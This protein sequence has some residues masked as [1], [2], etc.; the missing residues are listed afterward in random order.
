V[1]STSS[2]RAVTL[3]NDEDTLFKINGHYPKIFLEAK[4]PPKDL[5]EVDFLILPKFTP[6]PSSV[7]FR[8][9]RI[10]FSGLDRS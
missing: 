1:V 6:L 8:N 2:H 9:V 3:K 7:T 4:N 5:D 10:Y